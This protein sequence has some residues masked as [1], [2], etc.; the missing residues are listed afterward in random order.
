MK[1]GIR[2]TA[3]YAYGCQAAASDSPVGQSIGRYL[4]T[5]AGE[6]DL[7]RQYLGH[8]EPRHYYHLLLETKYPRALDDFNPSIVRDY[9][10]G[11]SVVLPTVHTL[12]TPH[13]G[14]NK[15]TPRPKSIGA[16]FLHQGVRPYHNYIVLAKATLVGLEIPAVMMGVN[17]C[18]ISWGRVLRTQDDTLTVETWPLVFRRNRLAWAA[19]QQQRIK[20]GYLRD[21]RVGDLVSIHYGEARE[22]LT[23]AQV[24]RLNKYAQLAINELNAAIKESKKR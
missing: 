11:N 23:P 22:R 5:G 3:L 1:T 8:L 21:V 6:E 17:Q 14:F 20:F 13:G 18:L 24:A 10:F 7:W 12:F 15:L 2:L 19:R 4:A 9:W 16:Y